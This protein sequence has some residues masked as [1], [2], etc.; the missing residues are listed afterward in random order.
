MKNTIIMYEALAPNTLKS[1]SI[2]MVYT[3]F[4]VWLFSQIVKLWWAYI[5]FFGVC[6]TFG[7]EFSVQLMEVFSSLRCRVKNAQ[8]KDKP[9][10]KDCSTD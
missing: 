2:F 3:L 10:P 5:F 1:E 7:K 4:M 6:G 9:E 8:I